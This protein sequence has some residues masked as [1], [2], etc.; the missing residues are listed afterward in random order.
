MGYEELSLGHVKFEMPITQL[1]GDVE[2]SFSYMN[3][4]FRGKVQAEDI[5]LEPL[6]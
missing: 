5:N 4:D 6:I 1:R 2:S 3:S